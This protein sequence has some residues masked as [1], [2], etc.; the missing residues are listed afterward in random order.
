MSAITFDYNKNQIIE[1]SEFELD[2]V[3]GGVWKEIAFV[4]GLVA[5]GA[6]YTGNAPVALIAGTIA[7]VAGYI[8]S[9]DGK[10][11]AP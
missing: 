11:G 1:L 5:V 8:A 2:I 3:A 4:S 7:V 6:A 10:D 9:Q